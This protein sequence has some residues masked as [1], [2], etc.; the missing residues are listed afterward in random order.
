MYLVIEFLFQQ[1]LPISVATA[2]MSPTNAP[3]RSTTT[4][5]TT[6]TTALAT[7]PM[8][9]TNA[10]IHATAANAPIYATVRVPEAQS[11]PLQ[12]VSARLRAGQVLLAALAGDESKLPQ[13]THLAH[14]P[15]QQLSGA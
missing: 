7:A 9:P 12:S 4:T 6:T 10:P 15:R 5:T 11:I 14:L 13:Q 3:I 8:P 2:T 1:Q